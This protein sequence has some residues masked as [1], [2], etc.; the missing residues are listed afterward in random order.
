MR[1]FTVFS[2]LMA[3]IF[4]GGALAGTSAPSLKIIEMAVTTKIVRGK[5]ID[6][7][8]R[9]SSSSVKA[10]Y[11]FT[12]LTSESGEETTIKHVW[13]RDGEKAGE[14]VLPVK[15]ERWRTYSKKAVD[16]GLT[17]DW[18]VDVLDSGGNLLKSVQF[19]MN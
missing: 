6:S 10:L 16:K 14:Y 2:L 17:G 19:K 8:H 13:Y 7:V 12:R 4:P 3:L 1:L 18:R 15:G 5:P 9:I 11:C